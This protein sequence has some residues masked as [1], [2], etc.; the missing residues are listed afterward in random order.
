[1]FTDSI[2]TPCLYTAFQCQSYQHY[3]N[4]ECVSCGEDGSGCARLGLHADKWTGSNQSHVAFYLS[5]APGPHYCLYHYRLMLELADPEGL[6]G[7]IRGKLKVSFITD[8]GSIQDF[9]LTENGPLIFGRGRTYVFFVYHQEDL[10]SAS[11]A[12][13]HWTYEADMFN[14]LSYCVMFCDTS[15]PLARLTF[16]SVDHLA[17]GVTEERSGEA[18]MCHQQGLDVLQVVS[19]T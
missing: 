9:D 8:D 11:E 3:M 13:V 19:E 6:E 4:G 2:L 17:T 18:V 7:I 10:S 16:T 12:L 5:T 1:L 14:P 15:L